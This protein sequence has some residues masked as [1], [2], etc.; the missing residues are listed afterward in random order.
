MLVH[1]RN[2]GFWYFKLLEDSNVQSE[3]QTPGSDSAL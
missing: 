2:S 3:L 1:L